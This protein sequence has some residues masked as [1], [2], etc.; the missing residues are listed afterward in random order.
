MSARN[1]L[2]DSVKGVA[3]LLVV[4]GH[5]F[6]TGNFLFS[7]HMPLFFIF[8]GYFFKCKD[9]KQLIVDGFKRLV[10][11]YAFTSLLI[12][13][14][15]L[16]Y[17]IYKGSDFFR[18][19][20]I[21]VLWGSGSNS[22]TSLYFAD[23]RSIGAIWFL[24]ALFWCKIAYN[25]IARYISNRL[26]QFVTIMAI[27]FLSVFLDRYYINLPFSI[28]PGL[29]SLIFYFIGVQIKIYNESLRVRKIELLCI[30]IWIVA[31]V[32]SSMSMAR[33]YYKCWPID[34]LGAVGG[35]ILVYQIVKFVYDKKR[36][37]FFIWL[38][39]NS[40]AILCFHCLEFKIQLLSRLN[41]TGFLMLVLELLFCIGMTMICGMIPFSRTIFGII[42]K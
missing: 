34:I 20:L 31:A 33:C 7:F 37:P 8:S 10:S 15:W 12:L 27:F 26:F 19:Y 32:Y 28:L 3:I 16:V 25:V 36:I 21:R 24:L 2:I 14:F 41:C 23:I 5:I 17:D 22:H 1:E 18:D 13:L 40:L 4:I 35:S 39:K 38:G 30:L 6:D 11:P 9:L 29:S 42:R